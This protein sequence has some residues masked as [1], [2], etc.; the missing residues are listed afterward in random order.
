L[1]NQVIKNI[2][3][4]N[5]NKSI[6]ILFFVGLVVNLSCSSLKES[7]E[8]AN[9]I[10]EGEIARLD[11]MMLNTQP[12]WT[13]PGGE[14]QK[15]RVLRWNLLHQQIKLR[16]DMQNEQ[17]I[18]QTTL[19]LISEVGNND[20][21]VLD[22]RSITADSI[23]HADNGKKIAVTQDS[24]RLHASL[25]E[26][27]N[28]GDTLFVAIHYRAQPP[29]NAVQF[30]DP[31]DQDPSLP[32]QIWTTDNPEGVSHW[33]PTI[34]HPAERATQEMWISVDDSLQTVSNGRIM[35]GY[36]SPGDSLHTDYWIM[37]KPHPAHLFGFA[38]GRY[39][40][41]KKYENDIIFRHYTE[42]MHAENQSAI[43]RETGKIARFL[44][45]YLNISYPWHTYN[46]VPVRGATSR[47]TDHTG[48]SLLFDDT[49]FNRR[50]SQDVNNRDLFVH[51][52]ATHWF[53]SLVAPETWAQ[54]A[55]SKGMATY[56]EELYRRETDGRAAA[57]WH[58]LQQK[59]RYLDE[60]ES[61]RR[62]VIFS[63]YDHPSQLDDAHSSAKMS[64]IFRML[65]YLVGD[66]SWRSGLN[67]YL[68]TNAFESVDTEDLK[69]AFE[70]QSGMQ[71]DYFFDQWLHQPGHPT[72]KTLVD[73]TH[74]GVSIRIVQIQDTERQ[75]V[76]RFP[77][78]VKFINQTDSTTK[79]IWIEKVDSTYQFNI[80]AKPHDII[81]DP[82]DIQLAEIK[83]QVPEQALLKRLNHSSVPVRF[84]AL[85]KLQRKGLDSLVVSK[86]KDVAKNDPF[87]GVRMR[88]MQALTIDTTEQVK[89]FAISRTYKTEP[90]GRV[91]IHALHI[92]K[93]DTT[94]AAERYLKKMT[95]DT[96]Y[97]VAAEAIK[98]Y[99]KNFPESS[100]EQ[101]APFRHKESYK[102]LFK[103]AFAQGIRYSPDKR[104]TADLISMA[105]QPGREQYI[106]EAL[107][108][109]AYQVQYGYAQKYQLLEAC[110]HKFDNPHRQNRKLC[111][112]LIENFA[113]MEDLS[114]IE[115]MIEN[116][117]L[118]DVEEDKL[119]S[120][121]ETLEPEENPN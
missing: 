25:V 116:K 95:Q 87:W 54:I 117:E 97:F 8:G 15:L 118:Y 31:Q 72:L 103:T 48:L 71:L 50:A 90:V 14:P 101:L 60:A 83:E 9:I 4:A 105:H 113:E 93:D 24:V 21:L 61:F 45:D 92:L 36:T 88:A 96:S 38:A 69:T 12:A 89:E 74:Q 62:P 49:Q 1:K 52:L 59:L 42:L 3:I 32:T 110:Y 91:R 28:R 46:Q 17:I 10:T 35:A 51:L 41:T 79:Q 104:A 86:I 77:L 11:S 85:N 65:H 23:Y 56:M 63:R 43:Y 76:Y 33:V 109:L 68:Q 64:R 30:I 7:G 114:D 39:A 18:G 6:L 34:N 40:V 121:I 82:N 13:M 119:R 84:D 81:Y 2:K 112:N 115:Y 73:S 47:S 19:T 53:G 66:D 26:K 16:F 22:A 37:T 120:L 44:E 20:S 111:V 102:N 107:R 99:G 67:L 106:R 27:H 29:G 80:S 75:P 78:D 100:Y 5:V 108:G 57:D 94:K 98:M 58:S 70:R 55:L